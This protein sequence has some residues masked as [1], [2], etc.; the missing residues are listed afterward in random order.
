MR[1]AFRHHLP[2]SKLKCAYY[3]VPS[4]LFGLSGPLGAYGIFIRG[5]GLNLLYAIGILLSPIS[6][7]AGFIATKSLGRKLFDPMAGLTITDDGIYNDS[8]PFNRHFLK[9]SEVGSIHLTPNTIEVRALRAEGFTTLK[10]RA[11]KSRTKMYITTDCLKT[12]YEEIVQAL[13]THQSRPI[14]DERPTP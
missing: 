14:I 7:P 13:R 10:A 6:L 4:L 2:I 12:S 5:E 3:L 9:W 8:S 11:S 1:E